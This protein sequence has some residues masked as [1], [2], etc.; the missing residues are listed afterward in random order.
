M[1]KFRGVSQ[2]IEPQF[3]IE[4][5]GVL[6][7]RS[8]SPRASNEYDPFLLF[9]HFAFNDPVEGPIRGFPM[10]PHRGIET[11]T[12]MLEG[13]TQHRDSLGNAGLIGPGDVQW[14][15][16][17][18]GILHEEMP[19]RGP[20]GTIYGFQLWVNLPAALKMTTPHYQEVNAQSIPTDEKDGVKVRLVAGEYEGIKGPVTEIAAQPLYMDVT[21]EPGT[22][23]TQ[24]IPDGHTAVVYVFEGQASFGGANE[25]GAEFVQS[26]HMAVLSDGESLR[27]QTGTT[28]PVRFMLMAG[29]PFKEPIVPYGPFVMNTRQE[30]EQALT[31]LRNGTFIKE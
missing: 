3:V 25:Q 19:R 16:S 13:A 1:P 18:R 22:T 14:M 31:E 5:A 8:I 17:G 15:T 9:D 4:G 21:L 28:D 10:H 20:E 30:I 7:R 6:L 27:V 2:I 29:A 23:F 26:V 24:A 12:Y 11:V